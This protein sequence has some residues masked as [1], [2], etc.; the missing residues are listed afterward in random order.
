MLF[1]YYHTHTNTNNNTNKYH[2]IEAVYNIPS[3]TY[4]QILSG[5]RQQES[6]LSILDA[7]Y[8]NSNE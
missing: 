7:N 5:G 8:L 6:Y 1:N 4:T 2:H 3:M